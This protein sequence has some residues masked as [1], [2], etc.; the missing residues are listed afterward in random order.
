M[1]WL[2]LFLSLFLI[3]FEAVP[4]ALVLKGKKTLAGSIE[5]IYRAIV[6]L[7]VLAWA[8]GINNEHS[9]SGGNF[10]F[11]IGGYLLLRFSLFDLIY[12][13]IAGLPLTFIGSTK[14]SDKLWNRFFKW[15]N[16]PVGAFFGMLKFICF[17]IGITWILQN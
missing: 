1:N 6:T 15:T 17:L 2:S 12:N 16:F 4:E 9:V 14:I 13:K 7:I 8:I 11:V 10:I 3:V 5:F